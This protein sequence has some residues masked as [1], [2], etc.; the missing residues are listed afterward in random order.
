MNLKKT[1]LK[2]K[3]VFLRLKYIFYMGGAN[4]EKKHF[5]DNIY[6]AVAIRYFCGSLF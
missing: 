3:G 5:L 4:F 2:G 1:P 6:L